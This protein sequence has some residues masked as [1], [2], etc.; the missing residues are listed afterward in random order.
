M[1]IKTLKPYGVILASALLLTGCGDSE[2]PT[3][4]SSTATGGVMTKADVEKII[5][6]YL[7]EKP[8]VLMEA[9]Q[10]FEKKQ[11][12][13]QKQQAIAAIKDNAK[14]LFHSPLSPIGGNA[15]GDV[16]V[17]EFF[18]YNCPYC[19]QSAKQLNTFVKS[20]D[21]IRVVYKE[22]PIFG[23]ASKLAAQAALA[24]KNQGKY[25]E[26]HTSLLSGKGRL[27]AAIIYKKAKEVGLD[28]DKLKADMK[29][30]DVA[31]EIN[32]VSELAS[33]LGIQG[34]P[35]YLV[36]NNL[37]PGA[38]QNLVERMKKHTD[39]LRKTPCDYC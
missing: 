19:R 16:T 29:S 9:Q 31:K 35:A 34:T 28:I 25:K 23:G 13:Q 2:A 11:R 20:D 3:Q 18:D 32:Q 21:K 8:E 10:A 36:G 17:I 6:D 38:P 33:K 39:T 7:I 1:I 26:F 24:S 15:K 30:D 27:T 22:F 12:K 4:K 37:I 5:R 14:A